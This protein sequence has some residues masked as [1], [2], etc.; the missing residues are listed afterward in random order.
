MSPAY[1]DVGP[2]TGTRCHFIA[3][4]AIRSLLLYRMIVLTEQVRLGVLIT[5]TSVAASD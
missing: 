5:D 2:T 3:S 4:A 1:V